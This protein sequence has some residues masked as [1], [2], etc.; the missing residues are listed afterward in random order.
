[1]FELGE[2]LLDRVEIGTVWR[3]EEEFGAD[4]ADGLANGLSLVA[5]EIVPART[6][7]VAAMTTSPALRLG[8][9][10]SLT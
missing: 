9:R 5:A 7:F 6:K 10:N 8:R 4:A 1:V 2:D 3:Q